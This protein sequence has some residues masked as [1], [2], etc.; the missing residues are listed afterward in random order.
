[1]H[2]VLCTRSNLGNDVRCP[3]CGQGFLVFWYRFSRDEQ[4]ALRQP[5]ARALRAQHAN[6]ATAVGGAHS[7]EEFTVPHWTGPEFG[8]PEL[9]AAA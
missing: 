5:I 3:V 8:A 1:M 4:D 9:V 6:P 2:H 7:A